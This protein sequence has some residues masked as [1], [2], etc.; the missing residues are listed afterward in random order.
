LHKKF[1]D[2][3]TVSHDSD[4]NLLESSSSSEDLKTMAE[5][6]CDNNKNIEHKLINF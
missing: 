6:I 5:V 1:S 2:R 4:P 3:R